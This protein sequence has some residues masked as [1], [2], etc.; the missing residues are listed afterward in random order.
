MESRERTR[1][2]IKPTRGSVGVH[3]FMYVGKGMDVCVCVGMNVCRYE[4]TVK[5]RCK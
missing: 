4:S 1:I 5:G 3:V 2:L